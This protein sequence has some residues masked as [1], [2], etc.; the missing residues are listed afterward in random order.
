MTGAHSLGAPR[1]IKR[2]RPSRAGRLQFRMLAAQ[3]ARR[4][5]FE[6]SARGLRGRVQ[7]LRAALRFARGRG[8]VP[9]LQPAFREV[10]F[11]AVEAPF[12]GISPKPTRF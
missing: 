8:T 10:P 11:A 3:Y 5:T 12:G 7:L 1:G 4:D 6:N 9:P 2:S